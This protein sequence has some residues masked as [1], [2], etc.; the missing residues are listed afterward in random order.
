VKK[1]Y[2]INAHFLDR[3]GSDRV[4]EPL[5]RIFPNDTVFFINFYLSSFIEVEHRDFN[6]FTS[7]SH[8]GAYLSL[9]LSFLA[10]LRYML[11]NKYKNFQADSVADFE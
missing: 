9:V 7:L 3:L 1:G 10:I 6:I 2:E 4:M 5:S 11:T 8:L